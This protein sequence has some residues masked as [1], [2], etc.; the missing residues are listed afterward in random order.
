MVP[1]VPTGGTQ[2]EHPATYLSPRDDH[3][4]WQTFFGR[5]F[6]GEISNCWTRQDWHH[7]GM[8]SWRLV[9]PRLRPRI[10][11][12][13]ERLHRRS[14]QHCVMKDIRANLLLAWLSRRFP[15]RVIYLLRHPCAVVA[16]RLRLQWSDVLDE[17]VAQPALVADFLRPHRQLIQ[18]MTTPLQR[19]TAHWCIENLVPLTQLA[20]GADWITVR[21]EECLASPQAVFGGLFERLDLSPSVAT[22]A[23]MAGLVS[24]PSVNAGRMR[25]WHD[26]LTEAEGSEVL[27]I[28]GRFGVT[29]YGRELAPPREPRSAVTADRV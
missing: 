22:P 16:S 23:K 18:S 7:A 15:V 28:C 6:N 25:S 3:G 26:P 13:K 24:T 1:E 11:S 27:D 12:F 29:L 20:A 9:P 2:G 10:A 19:M 14:A 17:V 21:Y 8:H 4:E 5:L